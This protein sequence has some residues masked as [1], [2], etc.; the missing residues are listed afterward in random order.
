MPSFPVIK[1]SGEFSYIMRNGL[2]FYHPF[3]VLYVLKNNISSKI[4]ICAGKKLGKAVYRNRIKRRI[5]E[6]VHMS[7]PSFKEGYSIIVVAR[8][9]SLSAS[10]LQ[11]EEGL[12]YLFKKSQVI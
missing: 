8:A 6:L 3:F 4:G 5:R 11:L 7:F 9:S 2:I 1:K 12:L 10:F